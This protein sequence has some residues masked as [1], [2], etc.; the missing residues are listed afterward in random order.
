MSQAVGNSALPSLADTSVGFMPRLAHCRGRVTLNDVMT[1]LI[2]VM[3][4]RLTAEAWQQLERALMLSI[5][6][7]FE[8]MTRQSRSRA[9]TFLTLTHLDSLEVAVTFIAGCYLSS[10]LFVM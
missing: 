5:V 8:L 4:S 9:V 1:T 6:P 7:R 3:V 2:D 10:R